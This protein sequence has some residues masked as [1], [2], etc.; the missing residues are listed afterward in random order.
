MK[1][2]LHIII[3]FLFL[4]FS[5]LALCEEKQGVRVSLGSTSGAFSYTDSTT[6]SGDFDHDLSGGAFSV[7]YI[8][9]NENNLFYGGGLSSYSVSGSRT[10]SKDAVSGYWT[11]Y[12]STYG[13]FDV[14][15]TVKSFST[16]FLFG[17][18]GYDVG[19]SDKA[20]FQPN[21]RIGSK[22]VNAQW[23]TEIEW[24]SYANE[25]YAYD[26]S[27]SALGLEIDL[28]FMYNINESFGVGANLCICASSLEL[29]TG[30]S[31]YK[32][33]SSNVFNILADFYF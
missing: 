30:G 31:N 17:L 8:K 28:P 32:F 24:Q 16:S 3:I 18:I 19:I 20:S 9:T 15:L 1:K 13:Y 14:Y 10:G 22:S 11:Y 23:T 26:E 25:S 4:S 33:T 12:S 5:S 29:Y 7:S 2:I 6:L 21:L 27:A